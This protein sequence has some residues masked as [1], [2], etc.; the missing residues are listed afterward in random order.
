MAKFRK[1]KEET[2]ASLV[3]P[4]RCAGADMNLDHA[5]TMGEGRTFG[6]GTVR[7]GPNEQT[8]NPVWQNN[9]NPRKGAQ[10]CFQ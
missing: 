1:T 8:I 2:L 5:E 9:P 10:E 3:L 7:L 6:R 4:M